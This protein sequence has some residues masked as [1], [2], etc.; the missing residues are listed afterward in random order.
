MQ[1][2]ETSLDYILAGGKKAS[3]HRREKAATKTTRR[4][5]RSKVKQSQTQR[6]K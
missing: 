5:I 3:N 4:V 6:K 1:E 2:C